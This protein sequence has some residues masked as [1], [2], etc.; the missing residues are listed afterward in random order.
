MKP[1]WDPALSDGCSVPKALRHLIP[2]LEEMCALLLDCCLVHDE[3]FYYGGTLQ[4]FHDA[5]QRLYEAILPKLIT[6]YGARHG[7]AWAVL[8]YGAVN[9]GWSHWNSGRTWDGR[10]MWDQAGSESP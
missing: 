5:N 6:R 9:L 1:P 2:Q 8:W 4:D 10:I 3:A 7:E